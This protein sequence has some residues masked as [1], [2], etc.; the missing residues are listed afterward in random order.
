[1]NQNET[2]SSKPI[3]SICCTT[4]NLE[5]YIGKTLE[6]F[7]M[8][9]TDF[10]F[11]IIIYDDASKDKTTEII[12]EYSD[13]FPNKFTTIFQKK[14][15]YH[16][17]DTGLGK[18]YADF[19]LPRC[20]GTYIALCDGDD[21]WTDSYKL[22]TQKDYLKNQHNCVACF[23]N[24]TIHYEEDSS[25]KLYQNSLN[26]G[27]VPDSKIILNGGGLYPTSTLFFKKQALLNS[28]I[29]KNVHAISQN[30]VVDTLFIYALNSM[31]E[32]GYLDIDT[33]IYRIWEQGLY[34][35]I[36]G[37]E[38]KVAERQEQQI[39]G[40]K[41]IMPYLEKDKLELLKRKVSV[42]SLYVTRYGQ[43][44]NRYSYIKEMTF[45]EIIKL[46]T[47]LR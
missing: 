26:E 31:G 14:N 9:K 42:E 24:A 11:E 30:L 28:K 22:Q 18:I 19:L 45:K 15:Q 4:Y 20:K 12:Q 8:Q 43:N 36:R 16:G 10:P 5:K 29:F 38:A 25:E 2:S 34:S 41:N 37:D 23:T 21:Y 35:S 17:N 40:L 32:I 3:V 6:S 44:L 27:F 46:I 13:K 1:M 33:A 39:R 7:L 47:G